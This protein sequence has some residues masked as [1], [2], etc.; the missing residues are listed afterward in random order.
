MV[1]IKKMVIGMALFASTHVTHAAVD[2]TPKLTGLQDSCSDIFHLMYD[3]PKK[4]KASIIKKS[5]VKVKDGY[6]GHN[7][8][9]TYNLKDSSVFGLSLDKIKEEINDTDFHYK[10]FSM[11]FKDNA[12]LKLRPSF[13]YT[14][15][16][17]IG[18]KYKITA[19]MPR[20]GTYN[21]NASG[22][23]VKYKNMTSGYEVYSDG[24]VM[25]CNTELKFDKP[26]KAISCSISCG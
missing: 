6:G 14:A 10:S 19:D 2:W 12:F 24:E 25:S 22:I 18:A 20:S 17:E 8:T 7:I 4:Y 21:D 11:I 1:M 23:H 26:N 9:T 16:S 15:E 5:D 3:L 13:Y